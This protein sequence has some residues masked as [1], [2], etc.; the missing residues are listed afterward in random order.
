MPI[1]SNKRVEQLRNRGVIEADVQ[2]DLKTFTIVDNTRSICCRFS[3]I[4]LNQGFRGLG[5]ILVADGILSHDYICIKT[6]DNEYINLESLNSSTI[7]P[8]MLVIPIKITIEAHTHKAH[9]II[10]SSLITKDK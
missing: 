1:E 10:D 2:E 7:S 6:G 8:D 9:R 4:G 3:D 5:D